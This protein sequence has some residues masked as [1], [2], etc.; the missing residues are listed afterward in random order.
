MGL[1]KNLR[2]ELIVLRVYVQYEHYNLELMR[3]MYQVRT[4]DDP[5]VYAVALGAWWTLIYMFPF[6]SQSHIIMD[7]DECTT[8]P[9]SNKIMFC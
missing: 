2:R 3:A 9:H 5:L 8:T 4:L 7:S 1:G 6:C